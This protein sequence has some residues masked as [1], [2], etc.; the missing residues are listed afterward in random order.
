MYYDLKSYLPD[1]I[2]VKVDRATMGVSLE[3]RDPFL[4]HKI[5]E[6]SSQLPVE[7][8]YKEG[9]TKYILRKILYKYLPKELVDRKKQGF[10]API[11]EWFRKDL[12]NLYREYLSESSVKRFGIFNAKEVQKLLKGYW[13]R[14]GINPKKV[15]LLFVF[16]QWAEKWL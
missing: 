1:D 2:L 6:W 5:V 9:K 11:Q 15:W 7:F 3:G 14:K 12:K 8:K 10:G 13:E 16:Q 4:D